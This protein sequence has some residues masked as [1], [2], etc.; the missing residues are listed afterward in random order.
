MSLIR[1]LIV[2]D[3][4]FIAQEITDYLYDLG[5]GV[6]A[7]CR[8]V[9]QSKK[10]LEKELPDLILLDIE[11]EG[12][13]NGVDLAAFIRQQKLPIPI[14]FLTSQTDPRII[15]SVKTTCPD[16]FIVKPF[17]ER[18]LAT[19]IEIAL[20]RHSL[21][22]TPL[23]ERLANT[24]VQQDFVWNNFYFVR[25]K[26]TLLK[27]DT[28]RI[29]W[30]EAE[31]NYT[32]L[33]LDKNEHYLVSSTLKQ[34]EDKLPKTNFIRIHRTYLINLQYLDKIEDQFVHLGKKALPIGKS[35]K[36]ELFQRLSLL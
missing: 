28:Q 20:Y 12:K 1:I 21:E 33:W 6:A 36:Q 32:H 31:D 9:Q 14:V 11:L 34:I 10:V 29:I 17:D 18:D 19:N 26:N 25:S 7:I 8:S 24:S 23:E 3:D 27:I 13:E 30:V 4:P 22:Q 35:Y 15:A 5:Y 2:E 16:G